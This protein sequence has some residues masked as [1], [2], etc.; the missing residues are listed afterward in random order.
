MN[1][2]IPHSW[3]VNTWPADVYPHSPARA[4]WLLRAHRDDLLAAKALSRVGREIV[5]IGRQYTKWLE[6][7]VRAVSDFECPANRPGAEA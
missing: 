2:T 3:S 1:R 5:V 6:Q 7:R 4:R